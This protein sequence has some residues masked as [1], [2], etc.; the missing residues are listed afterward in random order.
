MTKL[1]KDYLYNLGRVPVSPWVSGEQIETTPA[2]IQTAFRREEIPTTI[3][4]KSWN[5]PPIYVPVRNLNTTTFQS[6]NGGNT[7]V[8]NDPGSNGTGNIVIVHK[9]GSVIQIDSNGTVFIKSMG[10]NYNTSE[11]INYQKSSGDTCQYIG[12]EWDLRID[13]GKGKVYVAGDL[14][15]ECENFNVTARRKIT[16]NAAESVNMKGSRISA[17]AYVDNV[18][19]V[20]KKIRMGTSEDFSVVSAGKIY[21]TADDSFN[22]KTESEV[23]V[24]SNTISMKS[25]NDIKLESGNNLDLNVEESIN[26]SSTNFIANLEGNLSLSS[27]ETASLT[28]DGILSLNG[29]SSIVIGLNI[30][31]VGGIVMPVIFNPGLT[32]PSS[33]EREVVQ[34]II[35]EVPGMI[36]G[37]GLPSLPELPS[38]PSFSLPTLPDISL[39]VLLGIESGFKPEVTDLPEVVG[40]RFSL[41]FT[42]NTAIVEPQ[43]FDIFGAE[44]DDTE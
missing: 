23:C 19:I 22:L 24:E 8:I 33:I 42:T 11:G 34:K 9:S 25:D 21:M 27:V 35:D 39:A 26:F 37:G 44:V 28:T 29:T 40:G 14:D 17:E 4:G 15:I 12:G 1:T 5:E 13:G 10:D 38:Y 30:A 18:D 41:N 32:N 2:I 31:T 3:E 6:K 43:P 7:L 20:G 16:L 36:S